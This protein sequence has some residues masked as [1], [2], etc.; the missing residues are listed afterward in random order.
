MSKNEQTIKA[1]SDMIA[2]LRAEMKATEDKIAG[3]QVALSALTGEK[4]VPK[5]ANANGNTGRRSRRDVKIDRQGAKKTFEFLKERGEKATTVS[6]VA[7]KFNIT[8]EA[9]SQRLLKLFKGGQVMRVAFGQYVS[10]PTA[11]AE[12]SA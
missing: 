9:A 7:R 10:A 12:A 5:P 6:M 3:L 11:K 8:P 2:T 1:I 4:Q